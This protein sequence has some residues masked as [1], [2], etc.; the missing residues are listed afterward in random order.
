MRRLGWLVVVSAMA[1]HSV[2]DDA[3]LYGSPD[4]FDFS[5]NPELLA[6]IRSSPYAF[7]R[8]MNRAFAQTVCVELDSLRADSPTVNLHGDAHLEQYAITPTG[9]GL[10]DFDDSASGPAIVDLVRFGVSIYLAAAERGW[11]DRRQEF[12]ARFLDGYRGALADAA[13]AAPEPALV[14]RVRAGFDPDRISVLA[15]SESLM[16][17]LERESERSRHIYDAG[18]RFFAESMQ[19]QHPT[20]PVAFFDVKNMGTLRLGIGSALDEKFLFRV[21][22]PSNDPSDD[23]ILEAK[24]LRDLSGVDCVHR[25]RNDPF[26]ILAAQ[27]RLAYQPY[28]LVG[29][30][31]FDPDRSG[32]G[33][34]GDDFWD[35]TVFWIHSWVDNYT[36][37]TV[38]ASLESPKDLAEVVFDVGVQLGHGHTRDIAYPLDDQLRATLS[39]AWAQREES[40]VAAVSAMTDQVMDAWEAFRVE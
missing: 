7:F 31:F 13:L 11:S 24:E 6:S 16:Q 27:S 30:L 14:A 32:T 18:T 26:A 17:P 19:E 10:M 5:A 3:P 9:R 33:E 36:E 40:Y 25:R 29:Y 1:C 15:R 38:D 21:E 12:L 4:D 8:F 28:D 37:I 39:R 20:L 34:L 2:P 23:V 22:G 35:G